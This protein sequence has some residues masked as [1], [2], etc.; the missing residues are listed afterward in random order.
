MNRLFAIVIAGIVLVI[1]GVVIL[2]LPPHKHRFVAQ[3]SW[4]D[5]QPS[6]R[7]RVCGGQDVTGS[8]RRGVS[9]YN[10]KFG[11][12][13]TATPVASGFDAD[14][15]HQEYVNS[16]ESGSKNCDVILL[17]VAYM[18][19]FAAKG[20]LYDMT[21]YLDRGDHRADFD[22]QM[23]ATAAY[24]DKLWG[25]PKQRDVGVLYYRRDL[26][27]HRPT[28]WPDVFAQS[29]RRTPHD[30]P[31][32]RVQIGPYEG[33]TV[34]LLELAYAAGAQQIVSADGKTAAIYQPQVIEVVKALRDARRD[35][36][37]PQKDQQ[38]AANLE[39]YDTGRA[40]FLR[41]WPLIEHTLVTDENKGHD[42]ATQHK[43]RQA[44]ANTRIVPLPPWSPNGRS[45]AIL[46]GHDLVIPRTARNPS[47][48]L[49]LVDYFTSEEQVRKD[50]E[51]D[52][53]LSVLKDLASE[54]D[55]ETRLTDAV[56]ATHV[57]TRPAIV[58]YADVSK[59]IYC[60]V[61]AILAGPDEMAAIEDE[62]KQMQRDVQRVLRS[63]SPDLRS[64]GC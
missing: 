54:S 38:D 13:S 41:D 49:A 62:L 60:G 3:A 33:L 48:A 16:V 21:P 37:I 64:S 20:L 51:D 27:A 29:K 10:L 5:R 24:H 1:V 25:V 28:S 7:V 2:T 26:V 8:L 47:G 4:L 15:Q 14:A 19:E 53:Q 36:A 45:V 50:V 34:F 39:N 11:P 59:I 35:H 22:H 12:D 44:Q 52:S 17:D 32:L 63:D 31:G 9:G 18:R 43:R 30:P 58:D 42:P 46:G 57:M 56:A 6:G 40:R 55:L 23:I 61:D